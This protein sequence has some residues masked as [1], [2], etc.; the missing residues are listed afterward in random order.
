LLATQSE[1]KAQTSPTACCPDLQVPATHYNNKKK[2]KNRKV[3]DK[4]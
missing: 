3:K 4:K 1:L 2:K